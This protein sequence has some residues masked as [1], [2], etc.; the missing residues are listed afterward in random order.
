[1]IF[2]LVS[3]LLLFKVRNDELELFTASQKLLSNY[4][5]SLIEA[6]LDP[7]ITINIEGKITDMNEATVKIT[8]VKREELIGSDFFDY[9]T[10]PNM[11]RE[12]YEEVFFKWLCNRPLTRHKDGKNNRCII[13]RICIQNDEGKY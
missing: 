11:A 9:F 6:S 4:S 7:L 10:Q 8:G 12:V 2:T 5:L 13:Q 3:L 1:M